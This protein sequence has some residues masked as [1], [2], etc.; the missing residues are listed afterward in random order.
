MVISFDDWSRVDLR[1]GLI[2]SAE[3]VLG[4]DKLFKLRV[5][6]GVEGERTI[7]AGLK[8]FYSSEELINKKTIFVFNLA[9]RVISGIESQGMILAMRDKNGGYKVSFVSGEVIEGTKLE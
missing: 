3:D 6:F 5:C 2:K 8:Q 7:L 9:P 1:V 4:K